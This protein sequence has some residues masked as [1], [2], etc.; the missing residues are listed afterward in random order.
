MLGLHHV[1]RRGEDAEDLAPAGDGDLGLVEDLAQLG[2]RQEQQVHQEQE[3]HQL[4]EPEPP[5][6]AVDHPDGHDGGEGE[7][8]E[9][10]GE[11]EH[12]REP[13]RGAHLRPVLRGDGVVEALPAPALQPVGLHDR[14][15][16]HQLRHL[17]ERAAH[18]GADLVVGGQLAALQ[19]AQR[20][21]QRE[22]HERRSPPRAARSTRASRRPC[23]R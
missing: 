3:R 2:D 19:V 5:R 17:R 15:A 12:H 6:R 11:R 10:V 21:Q 22:E 9:Q 13:L 23:R 16:R 20:G 1:D 4:V 7:G 14:R 8:A 18:R